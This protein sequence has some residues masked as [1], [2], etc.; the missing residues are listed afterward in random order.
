MKPAREG[1]GAMRAAR[2]G[3]RAVLRPVARWWRRAAPPA[4]AIAVWLVLYA[5][6]AWP[7]AWGFLEAAG[8]NLL[9]RVQGFIL[10]SAALLGIFRA[11]R[12]HPLLWAQYS[13]WLRTTPWRP[14]LPLP[15]GP[16]L[17]TSADAVVIAALSGVDGL[18]PAATVT[19]V[20]IAFLAGYLGALGCLFLAAREKAA[21]FVL[22]LGLGAM[23]LA[24]GW[25]GLAIAAGLY[26]VLCWR[27][28]PSLGLWPKPDSPPSG[29]QGT[30]LTDASAQGVE[31]VG[32]PLEPL[33]PKRRYPSISLPAGLATAG[34]V[35]FWWYVFTIRT[36]LRWFLEA[37][38]FFLVPWGSVAVAAIIRLGV[39]VGAH[40]APTSLLGRLA[41][42]RF[43]VPGYDRI[44]LAPIFACLAVWGSFR[45]VEAAGTGPEIGSA[46]VLFAGLA[47][48]L[49]L[50]PSLETFSLT[51]SHAIRPPAVPQ[52]TPA[53]LVGA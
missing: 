36:G 13:A 50:G 29:L 51:G 40:K 4:P 37:R 3:P 48:A 53:R 19:W 11:L 8:N 5:S 18:N 21:G 28:A 15:L 42:G 9:E 34:L 24:G 38:Q 39:Y 7:W 20:P 16:V 49:V 46:A 1:T 17:L 14:G 10:A 26:A 52:G 45:I 33:S 47:C 6:V 35:A 2:R 30:L 12:W 44:F 31:E 41:S 27:L 43:V 22:L 23:V 25:T 32:F